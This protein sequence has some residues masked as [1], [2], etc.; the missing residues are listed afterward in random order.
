MAKFKVVN[1]CPPPEATYN[2]NISTGA[3][4]SGQKTLK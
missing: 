3:R 2:I 1:A 4:N